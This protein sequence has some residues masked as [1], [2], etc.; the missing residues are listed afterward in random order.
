M[1]GE[2]KLLQTFVLSEKNAMIVFFPS[3]VIK[4]VKNTEI[5]YHLTWDYMLKTRHICALQ[6]KDVANL[7]I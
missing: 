2:L 3:F 6:I 1:L 5:C 4:S 7:K